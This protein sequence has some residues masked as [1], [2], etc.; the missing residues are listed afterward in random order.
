MT[1]QARRAKI[2]ADA[3]DIAQ[4]LRA[5]N[6]ELSR[7]PGAAASRA[8]PGEDARDHGILDAAESMLRESFTSR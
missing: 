4:H 2:N 8:H 7:G 6:D 1:L 5:V 3:R